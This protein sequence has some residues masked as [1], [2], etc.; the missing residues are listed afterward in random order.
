VYELKDTCFFNDDYSLPCFSLSINQGDVCKIVSD[1]D[2]SAEFFLRGLAT[3]INVRGHLFFNGN[4]YDP[5]E[6]KELIWL[7]RKFAYLG[8]MC[9]LLSNR[10]ILDN[11]F[12]FKLWEENKIR[13]T[14]DDDFMA[15]WKRI[16]KKED[17]YK[18]PEHVT[19][20]IV[21]AAYI[22]K[23]FLKYPE[24]VM[25]ERPYL[26]TK[27]RLGGLL[28]EKIEEVFKTRIPV[29]FYSTTDF[30]PESRITHY[31]EINED[32]IIKKAR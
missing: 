31:I 13:I 3:L 16:G 18:R 27:G 12:L 15:E 22:L 17:L 10:N 24:I 8:P 5:L 21:G 23:E 26:F 25:L 1:N 19:E 32:E 7:K 30:I 11:I 14:P 28:F 4:E 29:V 20:D 6:Y 2:I 9:S